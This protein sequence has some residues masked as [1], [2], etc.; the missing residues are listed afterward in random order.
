MKP[1]RLLPLLAV[2]AIC[3]FTLKFAGLLLGNDYVLSGYAPAE[4]Q[5]DQPEQPREAAKPEP[6]REEPSPA[7]TAD[8][9]EGPVAGGEQAVAAPAPG[10]GEGRAATPADGKQADAAASQPPAA[11]L[12]V[13]KDPPSTEVPVGA[14][15]DILISL[16]E[17]RKQLEA[18]AREL[19]LRENLIAVAENRVESRIVELK[20]VE[21]RIETQLAKRDKERKAEYEK[22]VALYAKMKPKDA[23]RILE[24]MDVSVLADL[25]RQMSARTVSP[26]LAEMDPVVAKRVTMELASSGKDPTAALQSLP[27]ITSQDPSLKPALTGG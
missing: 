4:A 8:A 22:L 20:A 18:R 26:I 15:K 17:R 1:V 10:K 12:A 27:K 13:A 9:G 3:L 21:K 7:D 23:A 14:E 6:K 25:I 24:R 11:T 19:D 5:A 2:A 16:A